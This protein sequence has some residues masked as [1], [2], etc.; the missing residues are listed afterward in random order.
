MHATFLYEQQVQLEQEAVLKCLQTSQMHDGV[1]AHSRYRAGCSDALGRPYH[2]DDPLL[3]RAPATVH[4]GSRVIRRVHVYV[5]VRG[6][7]SDFLHYLATV[8]DIVV[9]VRGVEYSDRNA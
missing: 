9:R 4:G 5:V 6:L 1:V 3:S 7:A 2:Q 8:G